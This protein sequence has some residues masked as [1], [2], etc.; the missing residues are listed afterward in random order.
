[1]TPVPFV[2]WTNSIVVTPKKRLSAS[3][4]HGIVIEQSPVQ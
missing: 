1:M 2:K 4:W 3:K